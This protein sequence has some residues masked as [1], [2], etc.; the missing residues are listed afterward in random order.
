MQ[1]S[2]A[3][4]YPVGRQH[5]MELVHRLYATHQDVSAAGFFT[6]GILA[7]VLIIADLLYLVRL[8]KNTR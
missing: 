1:I 8:E 3:V 4:Q 2:M 6:T 7:A 5:A